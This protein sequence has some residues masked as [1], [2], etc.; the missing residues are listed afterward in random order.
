MANIPVG[1]KGE[2]RLLVTNDV[3]IDFLGLESARVLSTPNVIL[4]LEMTCRNS[5]KPLLDEG[6]DT[7]GTHV[8]VAHLAATPVG[9]N[10]TFRSEV[11]SVEERR[12]NFKVEAFNDREKISEGTHQ[13]AV[14]NIARFASRLAK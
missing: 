10:V 3:S 6:H 1:T 9:M 11:T 5:V 7:V 4:W 14:I 2:E 8:N 13:R 12:V